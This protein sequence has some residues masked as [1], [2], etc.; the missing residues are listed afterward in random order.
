MAL[1]FSIHV[2]GKRH[3][4]TGSLRRG[5]LL[6]S[7]LQGL[8]E[9][10]IGSPAGSGGTVTFRRFY[11]SLACRTLPVSKGRRREGRGQKPV[12]GGAKRS[13]WLQYN[14]Q[15][16]VSERRSHVWLCVIIVLDIIGVKNNSGVSA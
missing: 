13:Y 12:L 11:T 5:I 15:F 7:P 1:V 4:S 2:P 10:R 3:Q 8:G 6:S 14:P 9:R 16:T